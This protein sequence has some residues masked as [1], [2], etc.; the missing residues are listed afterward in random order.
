TY[1]FIINPFAY[2]N[3]DHDFSVKVYDI[4]GNVQT[5]ERSISITQPETTS[6]VSTIL[7]DVVNIEPGLRTRTDVIWYGSFNADPWWETW[8]LD[9]NDDEPTN[10]S[11]LSVIT[12]NSLDGKGLRVRYPGQ[13][14]TCEHS[15]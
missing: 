15:P 11:N 2:T 6:T 8:Y 3:G 1:N 10:Q 14:T 12:K 5:I 7:G 9:E 4:H 13:T